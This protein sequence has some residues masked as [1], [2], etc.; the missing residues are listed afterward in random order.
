VWGDD[1]EAHEWGRPVRA[2]PI[3]ARDRTRG[4]IYSY[5]PP[6]IC[7]TTIFPTIATG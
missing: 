5:M 1:K 3:V 6:R 2:G 4:R 7:A